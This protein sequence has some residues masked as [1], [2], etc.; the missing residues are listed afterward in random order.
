MLT[1]S[2][3]LICELGGCDTTLIGDVEVVKAALLRAA[4]DSNVTVLNAYFHRFSLCGVSGVL[5]IAE[6]HISVHTWPESGYAAID[7]FTCGDIAMPHKAI[8]VL[9]KAFR[10]QHIELTEL[11]RGIPQGAGHFGHQV[12]ETPAVAFGMSA[13]RP[14]YSVGTQAPTVGLKRTPSSLNLGPLSSSS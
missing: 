10:A 14:A 5:C 3:H 4:T 13:L 2:A 11:S 7:V 12:R 9:G 6:S 1:V 8:E